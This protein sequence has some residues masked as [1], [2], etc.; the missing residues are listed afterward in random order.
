LAGADQLCFF[1]GLSG[2]RVIKHFFVVVTDALVVL[3]GATTLRVQQIKHDTR[4]NGS[5]VM[6]GFVI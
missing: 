4:H 1:L 2:L 3:D 6:L 5:V